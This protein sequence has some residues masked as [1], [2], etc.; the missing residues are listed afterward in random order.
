MPVQYDYSCT[1]CR[2]AVDR[3][4]LV[5]KKVTFLSMGLGGNT[6]QSRVIDWLCPPCLTEDAQWNLPAF[7]QRVKAKKKNATA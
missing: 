6:I 1:R 7:K 2:K 3:D 4:D 5:V